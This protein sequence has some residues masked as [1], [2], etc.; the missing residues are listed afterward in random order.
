VFEEKRGENEKAEVGVSKG[1]VADLTYG[2]RAKAILEVTR[3]IRRA[4]ARLAES[5]LSGEIADQGQR[6][7]R[8]AIL[9]QARSI[10]QQVRRMELLAQRLTTSR[11]P[12]D[13]EIV[14]M[15]SRK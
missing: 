7:R 10:E 12:D 14:V 13:T 11:N 8:A 1:P 3:Q 15:R 9:L 6:L 2:E 5:P 4:I